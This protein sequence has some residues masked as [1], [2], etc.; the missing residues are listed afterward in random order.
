M[1]FLYG[2]IL[3]LALC[4][5]GAGAETELRRLEAA[6]EQA[7]CQQEMNT[8]SGEL[9]AYWDR[10]LHQVEVR[11]EEDLDPDTLA[12]YRAANSAWRGY[13]TAQVTL[14]GWRDRGGTIQPLTHNLAF[15]DLTR[16]RIEELVEFESALAE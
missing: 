5:R 3:T 15:I 13:R 2:L 6:L 10:T 12:V 14:V 7:Q 1:R 4:G 8:C 9:A 16:A 11:M